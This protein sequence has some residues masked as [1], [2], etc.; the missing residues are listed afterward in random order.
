M[1]RKE[2]GT[3]EDKIWI[4][5]YLLDLSYKKF[6]NTDNRDPQFRNSIKDEIKNVKYNINLKLSF[7][8]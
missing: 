5:T 8:M 3:K 7:T 1:G 6:T 4:L 2:R